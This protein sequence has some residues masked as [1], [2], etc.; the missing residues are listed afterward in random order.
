[1][2]AT[3][4][5]QTCT[6]H[7]KVSTGITQPRNTKEKETRIHRRFIPLNRVSPCK[8]PLILVSLSSMGWARPSSHV[9][10]KMESK[11]CAKVIP[12]AIKSQGNQLHSCQCGWGHGWTRASRTMGPGT[13]RLHLHTVYSQRTSCWQSCM[14]AGTWGAG[15]SLPGENREAFIPALPK[16]IG[17]AISTHENVT[18]SLTYPLK[19]IS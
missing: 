4:P 19:C 14:G 3:W 17:R 10:W 11:V 2:R 8:V 1:M 15:G 18:K 16:S 13:N 7:T 6:T 5:L 9:L 12:K